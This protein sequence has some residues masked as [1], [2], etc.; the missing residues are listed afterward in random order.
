M[1]AITHIESSEG[2]HLFRSFSW[3]PTL[4][5]FVIYCDACP[6]GMGFWYPTSKDGY[7]APTPVNIPSDVIFYYQS[8]CVVSAIVNVQSKA[9][10]GSKILI[11]TDNLNT[12]DIFRSL[13]CLPP[14]N[15]LLKTAIDILISKD[16]SLRV[17]HVPGDE[18]TVADALSRVRFSVALGLEPNLRLYTFNPPGLVGSSA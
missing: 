9:P 10:H 7:Y 8:L 4:A 12:V 6:N 16:Y 1:W 17:L 3:T 5:D 2:V 14:Y 15:H 13:R 18:N 11:Y